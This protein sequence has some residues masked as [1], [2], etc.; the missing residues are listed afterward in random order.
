[1]WDRIWK[2]EGEG[3]RGEG[4][5]QIV[6]G[7]DLPEAEFPAHTML[8]VCLLSIL[9]HIGELSI[10]GVEAVKKWK[11][12][13]LWLVIAV[14]QWIFWITWIMFFSGAMD[15]RER[16]QVC[17]GMLSVSFIKRINWKKQ[18]VNRKN[19]EKVFMARLH[20]KETEMATNPIKSFYKWCQS[21]EFRLIYL[22]N[23]KIP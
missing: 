15:L 18:L 9:Q 11:F 14:L 13:F 4:G 8:W 16:G 7:I 6:S 21:C 19:K 5:N 2:R 20:K 12:F 17:D 1:M 3:K 23:C 10:L 22:T